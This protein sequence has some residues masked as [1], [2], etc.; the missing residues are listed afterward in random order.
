VRQFYADLIFEMLVSIW[1]KL[2]TTVTPSV[3]RQRLKTINRRTHY[4]DGRNDDAVDCGRRFVDRAVNCRD[5]KAAAKM[6]TA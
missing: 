6:I 1:P 4:D 5:R 2:A 3:E